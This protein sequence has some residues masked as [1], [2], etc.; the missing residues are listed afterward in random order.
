MSRR[1]W[2]CWL[3]LLTAPAAG[4]G[5]ELG[6]TQVDASPLG[7]DFVT[8]DVYIHVPDAADWWT[9]GGIQGEV[10]APGLQHHRLLEPNGAPVFTAPGRETPQQEFA[11]FVSLPREQFSDK[12]FGPNGEARI[13][14]GFQGSPPP[15]LGMSEINVAFFQSPP[16]TTGNNVPDTGF[17]IRVT[18]ENDPT[19]S[20]LSTAGIRIAASPAPGLLLAQYTAASATHDVPSPLAEL[21]FGFYWVPE[22]ATFALLGTGALLVRRRSR[23]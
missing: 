10:L 7:P 11:T 14:A 5:V 4:G 12:R 13:A 2:N 21:E 8:A 23:G 22:P 19:I 3:A 16:S 9:V 17:I 1:F 20:G 18:L 15:M 6:V